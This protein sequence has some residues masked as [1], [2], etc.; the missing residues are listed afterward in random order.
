MSYCAGSNKKFAQVKLW[1]Q[2]LCNVD[3]TSEKKKRRCYPPARD[4]RTG[5]KEDGREK[6][7]SSKVEKIP[8]LGRT[9]RQG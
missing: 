4:D 3:R 9:S 7:L 2:L 6:N 8:A 5:K 1:A